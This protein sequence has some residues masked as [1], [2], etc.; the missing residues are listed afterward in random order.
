MSLSTDHSLPSQFSQELAAVY[1]L[2]SKLLICCARTQVP[3]SINLCI[4][5]L[6]KQPIDWNHLMQITALHGL[7]P[8]LYQNLRKFYAEAVPNQ[9]LQQLQ[10]YSR[11]IALQNT[12]A[13]K[14]LLNILALLEHHG[15]RAIPHPF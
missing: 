4:E 7:T 3:A 15:I 1:S 5:S 12:L 6:L 10:H 11:T 14:E 9:I 13:C 8:L 2:E